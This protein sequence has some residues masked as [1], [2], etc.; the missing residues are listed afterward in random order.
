MDPKQ[1]IVLGFDGSA[2][3]DS[4]A[5]VGCTVEKQPHVFVAGLWENPGDPRWRVPR[6]EVID[7]IKYM[8]T[9]YNVVELAADPWT[10]RTELEDL[11]QEFGEK[12]VL[13]WNTA[14]AQRMAPATDRMYQ[15]VVNK[16]LTHDGNESMANH[17]S[18]AVAKSSDSWAI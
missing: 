3:G 16:Q 12:R 17:F 15:A 5:L 13:M 14:Q 6:R 8:F 10:W 11:A 18:H 4:T 2:S 7:Q 1:K 9:H